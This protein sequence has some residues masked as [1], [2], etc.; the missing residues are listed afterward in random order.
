MAKL[1]IPSDA[2]AQVSGD[3]KDGRNCRVATLTVTSASGAAG[4]SVLTVPRNQSID[5]D[6]TDT[7]GNFKIRSDGTYIKF[8]S[9]VS[10]DI[11]VGV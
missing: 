8:S 10:F 7:T 9:S 5:L 1:A 2:H 11:S 6:A 3:C 4:T